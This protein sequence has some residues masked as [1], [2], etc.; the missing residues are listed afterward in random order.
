MIAFID[1]LNMR[2]ASANYTYRLAYAYLYVKMFFE[3]FRN[4]E[5]NPLCTDSFFNVE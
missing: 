1:E 5:V 3:L 2:L 4:L